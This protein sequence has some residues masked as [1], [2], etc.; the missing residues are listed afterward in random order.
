MRLM[1]IPNQEN[2]YYI[3]VTK[4]GSAFRWI[5][6]NDDA[7]PN[8]ELRQTLS[9][10]EQGSSP[11][12]KEGDVLSYYIRSVDRS[13]YDYLYSLQRMADTGT[14]PITNFSGGCL[15][16]FTAYAQTTIA[17]VYREAY[18]EEEEDYEAD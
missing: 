9:F 15:G 6:F 10:A 3:L 16:Y 5:V 8:R 13:A 17:Y 11:E 4:N 12:V 14:N 1:D 18:V 7:S 2:Y